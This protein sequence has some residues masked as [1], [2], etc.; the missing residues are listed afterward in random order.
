LKTY[1]RSVWLVA[2]VVLLCSCSTP[3]S[4]P[5]E[6]TYQKEAITITL[7]AD[8]QLNLYQGSPHTL[9][10]CTYQLKDPNAFNQL[11]DEREGLPKLLEC[12][13]FDG[14]VAY[15][16]RLVVQPGQEAK[17]YLDRAEGAK[18]LSVVAGYYNLQKATVVRLYQIPVDTLSSKPRD[19]KPRDLNI[20][21]Y[22]GPQ[23]ILET[24][25]K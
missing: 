22:L 16:K 14:S 19:S 23:A 10:L 21:L 12:G 3:V 24:K 18:Y 13:R 2:I 1:I 11:V 5:P 7:K 20:D 6:Y 15:A 4:R 8:P 25:G 9:V 17:E